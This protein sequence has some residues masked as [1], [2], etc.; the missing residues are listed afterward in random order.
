MEEEL[1][2]I[3]A[4]QEIVV[5]LIPKIGKFLRD[6][7]FTVWEKFERQALAVLEGMI[8]ASYARRCS[9]R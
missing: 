9:T 1:P 4:T 6:L 8:R 5:W 2:L 3:P 7:R